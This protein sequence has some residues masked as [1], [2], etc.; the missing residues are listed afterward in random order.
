M[1]DITKYFAKNRDGD[2][3]N[4]KPTKAKKTT[5][6][7]EPGI[8]AILSKEIRNSNPAGAVWESGTDKLLSFSLPSVFMGQNKFKKSESVD[9]IEDIENEFSDSDHDASQEEI[10][11]IQPQQQA[12]N[13]N[14]DKDVQI[15]AVVVGKKRK[16]TDN[17]IETY[18]NWKRR[19][20]FRT[21][22]NEEPNL[23]LTIQ[24]RIRKQQQVVDDWK[25]Q[26]E[27]TKKH[28]IIFS[29]YILFM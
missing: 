9:I 20:F 21:Q 1:M 12:E 27:R 13:N 25:D 3:N 17:D 28:V 23:E 18:S 8:E 4:K 22:K 6:F 26:L 15:T 10:Q 2:S 7:P 5:E 24:Q 11:E 29:L 14:E 19:H 16:F